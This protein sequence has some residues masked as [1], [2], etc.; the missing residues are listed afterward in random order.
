[1]AITLQLFLHEMLFNFFDGNFCKGCLVK[2]FAE[3]VVMGN[4]VQIGPEFPAKSIY[5]YICIWKIFLDAFLIYLIENYL[6]NQLMMKENSKQIKYFI[7][8][9][10]C[11][12]LSTYVGQ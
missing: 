4:S 12:L 6:T 8:Y 10:T 9:E 11:G 2:I 7:E 1:M 3:N 5:I